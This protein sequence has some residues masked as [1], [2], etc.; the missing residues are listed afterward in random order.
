MPFVGGDRVDN[1]IYFEQLNI[2]WNAEPML[3]LH[4]EA[5]KIMIWTAAPPLFRTAGTTE[6]KH[7][8]LD[9]IGE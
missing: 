2:G 6:K 7:T 1:Q 5:H 4:R 3:M 8:P 9:K